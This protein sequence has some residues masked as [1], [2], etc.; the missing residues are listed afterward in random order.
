MRIVHGECGSAEVVSSE[1]GEGI[2]CQIKTNSLTLKEVNAYCHEQMTAFKR[3]K[4]VVFGKPYQ[5]ATWAKF[6]VK[7]CVSCEGVLD[8]WI[9]SVFCLVAGLTI[10]DP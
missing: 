7:T 6:C 10:N 8:S 9:G 4:H 2:C 5:K 3:P 1:R